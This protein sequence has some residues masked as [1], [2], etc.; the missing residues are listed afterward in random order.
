MKSKW[1]HRRAVLARQKTSAK[2]E[3][4]ARCHP[5]SVEISHEDIRE[6]KESGECWMSGVVSFFAT[7]ELWFVI[8][9]IIVAISVDILVSSIWQVRRALLGSGLFEVAFP[10]VYIFE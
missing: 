8:A 4:W 10:F 9:A 3:Q 6:R 1:Y 2:I 5:N 7:S